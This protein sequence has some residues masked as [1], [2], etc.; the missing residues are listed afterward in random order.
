MECDIVAPLAGARP[1][2]NQFVDVGCAP[3]RITCSDLPLA[4]RTNPLPAHV[5]LDQDALV[6]D[7]DSKL[8]PR[9]LLI[10]QDLNF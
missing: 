7:L 4:L 8:D 10:F 3:S 1:P 5:Q 2:G 9:R 6:A